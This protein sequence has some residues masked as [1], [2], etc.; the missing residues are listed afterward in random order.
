MRVSA[1][2]FPHTA[3]EEKHLEY[4]LPNLLNKL[5]INTKITVLLKAKTK[6]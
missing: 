6:I 2:T 1:Q 5:V 3:D 4:L